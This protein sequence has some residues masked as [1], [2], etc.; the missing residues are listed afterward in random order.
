[1]PRS[2]LKKRV[3]IKRK[4]IIAHLPILNSF[5]SSATIEEAQQAFKDKNFQQAFKLIQPYA[6]SGDVVAQYNL[7]MMYAE[8]DGTD[9]DNKKA[10]S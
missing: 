9:I 8:V 2:K 1:M 7:A 6:E 4:T 3:I 5:T 10:T